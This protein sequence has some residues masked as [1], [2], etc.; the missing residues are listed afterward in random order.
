MPCIGILQYFETAQHDC[1]NKAVVDQSIRN[2]RMVSWIVK[3][4]WPS[5]VANL[6]CKCG[7]EN[8]FG[9]Y[10][11]N[12][13]YFIIPMRIINRQVCL[14][15]CLANSY[16]S[17]ISKSEWASSYQNCIVKVVLP[18]EMLNPF[19]Y[20]CLRHEGLNHIIYGSVQILRQCLSGYNPVQYR[21]EQCRPG[22][23]YYR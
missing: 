14:R 13:H 4:V 22:W 21:V 6:F 3:D 8:L 23:L 5:S 15:N 9:E 18:R 7:G 11:S 19:R 12:L 1:V 2:K 20:G 10:V 16:R 17:C